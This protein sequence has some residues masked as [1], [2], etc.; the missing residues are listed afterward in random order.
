MAEWIVSPWC[1]V[2]E[3]LRDKWV[4]CEYLIEKV[5]EW[6]TFIKEWTIVCVWDKVLK[7]TSG[8]AEIVRLNNGIDI[9][10]IREKAKYIFVGITTKYLDSIFNGIL[11]ERRFENA[12]S[13]MEMIETTLKLD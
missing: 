13:I 7:H 3:W 6:E 2:A 5:G 4:N 10:I 11:F 9:R 8:V 12:D 1:D